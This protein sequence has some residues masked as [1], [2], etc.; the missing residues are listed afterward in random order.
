MSGSTTKWERVLADLERR[1]A[2]GEIVD[3]FPTD[4]ELVDHYDV[5]RQTVREAV[6]R[7]RARGIVERHRGRGSFVRPEHL[8]QPVGTLYSLYREAQRHGHVQ[9]SETFEL[10]ENLSPVAAEA[11]GLPPDTTLFMMSR[12]RRV[13]DVPLAIDTVWLPQDIGRL[14]LDADMTYTSLYDE[15]ETRAGIQ[16]DATREVILPV[17][18][19]QAINEVLELEDREATFRLERTSY[20]EDRAIEWRISLVRG[21]RFAFVSEWS[22]DGRPEPP[23]FEAR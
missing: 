14:L 12:L 6:R 8:Q 20:V 1:L 16:V 11:L 23:R 18:P 3:R 17:T 7:L 10:Q 19:D 9:R 5:S 15:L 4:R 13:D 2:D 21:A 22:R